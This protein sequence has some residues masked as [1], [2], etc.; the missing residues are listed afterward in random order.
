MRRHTWRKKT[1]R[2]HA[3][4]YRTTRHTFSYR[5]IRHAI[6]GP[7]ENAAFDLLNKSHRFFNLE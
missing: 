3:F 6:E 1:L 7:I 5:V 4:P 2:G